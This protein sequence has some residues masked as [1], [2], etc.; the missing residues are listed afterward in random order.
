M[1]ESTSAVGPYAAGALR[2]GEQSKQL[3]LGFICHSDTHTCTIPLVFYLS[4]TPDT[5][6][7]THSP[8]S[9]TKA[10][11]VPHTSITTNSHGS[12]AEHTVDGDKARNSGSSYKLG[13]PWDRYYPSVSLPISLSHAGI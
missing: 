12:R 4:H 6:H 3:N 7:I 8:P 5:L 13:I 11:K 9:E 10:R 2:D 1:R